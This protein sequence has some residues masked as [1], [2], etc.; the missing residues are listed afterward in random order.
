MGWKG[1]GTEDARRAKEMVCWARVMVGG[2]YS[3]C[4]RIGR[5]RK[6]MALMSRLADIAIVVGLACREPGL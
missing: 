3:V 4:A 5:G 6:Y 1:E 2:G